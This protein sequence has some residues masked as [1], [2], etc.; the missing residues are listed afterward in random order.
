MDRVITYVDGFNLYF[1]MRAKQ[2]YRYYWL[3]I[4]QMARRLLRSNQTL[5]GTKYFTA[6]VSRP[7]DKVK[8]QGTYLE[9]LGTLTDFSIYYGHYLDETITCRNCGHTYQAHHEKM[10]DVNI[11]VQMLTDAFQ[12]RFDVAL[13]VSA[14][15]DL[16]GVI[17]TVQTLFAP[18]RVVSVFPP[19]RRSA[20]LKQVASASIAIYEST[21]A[22]CQF[23]N[24]I[25]K[26][27]GFVLQRP[28][29]WR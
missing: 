12:N 20:K 22:R 4:Q 18:K 8:R 10:T 3:D 21:L 26:P 5:V 15:G 1:G 17:E 16:A 9:A 19:A 28:Q 24:R 25:V 27:G 2:W 14:D 11:A 13:L 29:S 6:R 23:P 7:P